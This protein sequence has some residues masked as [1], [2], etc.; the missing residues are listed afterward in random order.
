M[1]GQFVKTAR[2]STVD[3]LRQKFQFPSVSGNHS[4]SNP[5]RKL[6]SAFIKSSIAP[7]N[8]IAMVVSRALVSSNRYLTSSEKPQGLLG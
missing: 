5:G 3:V 1:N 8:S 2:N 7:D 6:S 4:I